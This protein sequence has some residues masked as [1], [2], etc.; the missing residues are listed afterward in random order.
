VIDYAEALTA[1]LGFDETCVFGCQSPLYFDA[2]LKELLTMMKC[3]ASVCLV[4]RHLFSFPVPLLRYL[5]ENGVNTICWVSSAL[6]S[7]AVLGGL[8]A[9]KPTTL[10]TVVFGSEVFPLPHFRTWRN[11][12]PNADFWQLYGPTEATGMS[13]YF[14]VDRDF[15]EGERIPIGRPFD[16]TGLFLLGDDGKIADNEGEICLFG[17][18]LTLGYDGDRE[19]TDAA[20]VTMRC[21]DGVERR[22]YR[23]GD[24]ALRNARGELEY[25]G[26]RDGQIKRM[27]H[28]IELGEI[29][30]AALGCRGVLMAACVARAA[31][32]D[33]LLYYV[34]S[35]EPADVA[36]H[37][38][39]L[40][41][42][43]MLPRRCLALDALPQTENGKIDRRALSAADG[44]K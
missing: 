13:C 25:L 5:R 4:P 21:E 38:A 36:G 12:L 7:V 33:L 31:D 16:R 32:A 37:L 35:A 34:G 30:A 1:A 9:E 27:G 10:R 44:E 28:R 29:E 24:L 39:S 20:F 6:S 43:Y 23:T 2:P 19:R 8:A 22:V 42:R 11:A 41:P 15:E 3:G 17:D 26:R 18:C 14:K 40:L